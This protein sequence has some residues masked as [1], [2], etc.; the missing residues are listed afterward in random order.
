MRKELPARR[1]T[2]LHFRPIVS[3]RSTAF[4]FAEAGKEQR[5]VGRRNRADQA[6]V[7]VASR[8]R[9]SVQQPV[10][11]DQLEPNAHLPSSGR[12]HCTSRARPCHSDRPSRSLD[13]SMRMGVIEWLLDSDPSIR[14][15]RGCRCTWKAWRMAVLGPR[16]FAGTR[17]FSS[18]NQSTT[19]RISVGA[20]L[21]CWPLIIRNRCPSASAS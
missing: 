18:S 9:Q 13:E 11:N 21:D 8:I 5:R 2:A 10:V 15:Q 4:L 17:A 6:H 19:T 3:T 7:C 1:E 14:W 20:E 16:Y 12:D